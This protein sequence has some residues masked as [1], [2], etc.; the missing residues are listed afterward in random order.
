MSVNHTFSS[1]LEMTM[2]DRQS[3]FSSAGHN[4]ISNFIIVLA[5]AS[6]TA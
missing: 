3:Q 4:A 6:H 5:F 1:D 2:L